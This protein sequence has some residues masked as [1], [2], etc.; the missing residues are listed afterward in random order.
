LQLETPLATVTAYAQAARKAGVCVVLNA[1]PALALPAE[2]LANV[3]I[4]VVNEGELRSIAGAEGTMEHCLERIQ[5]PTV[6]VTLGARGC[7]ARHQGQFLTQAAY[8]VQAVD[9]TAAGDTFCGVLVA[10]LGK[11]KTMVDALQMAS[12]ASALTC[13]RAGAQS[14]IP[15]SEEVLAFLSQHTAAQ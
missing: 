2:L 11:G 15:H 4:L 12:A 7:V 9:T 1:A 3:D 14:S 10:H 5:V 8:P 6:V 13:T